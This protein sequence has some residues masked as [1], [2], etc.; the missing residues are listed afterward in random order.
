M[1]III[2]NEKQR[3]KMEEDLA[4]LPPLETSNNTSVAKS[5]EDLK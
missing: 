3:K 4:S 1:I 2:Q 5:K